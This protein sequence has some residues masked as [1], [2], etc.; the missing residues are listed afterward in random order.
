MV[1][2]SFT[3]QRSKMKHHVCAIDE[4]AQAFGPADVGGTCQPSHSK[5]ERA[6][7]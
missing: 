2:A 3:D 1:L 7:P 4:S 5:A 6:R